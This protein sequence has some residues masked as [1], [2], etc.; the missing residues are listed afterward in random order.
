MLLGSLYAGFGLANAGVGAVHSLSYPLGGRYGIPHG[1]ANTIML[2]PVMKFN[3]PAALEKFATIAAVMG[4]QIDDLPL[5]EAAYL[6]V[7]AV[8]S[9]IKDCNI[10]AGLENLGIPEEAF[11]EL[12]KVAMT[13]TRPLENNPRKVTMEDAIEMYRQVY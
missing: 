5:R 9:L 1:M 4:E 10:S 6:S 2:P 11:P 7:E 13:V 12:A 8:K 3:L